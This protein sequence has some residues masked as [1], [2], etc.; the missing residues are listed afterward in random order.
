MLPVLGQVANEGAEL[1]EI[2]VAFDFRTDASGDPDAT[3]PTLLRYHHLLWSKPLPSR[4]MFELVPVARKPFSLA[5]ES[6]LGT[7]RLTSDAVLPTF[8]RRA[9][10]QSIVSQV[11]T[12]YLDFM[13][14]ITYTVGGMML[15]PGN[16]VD[17]KWTINQA[18]G[19]IRALADRFDLT[20][21]CVRLHY[22]DDSRHPLAAVFSRYT[23][24]F[25]LFDDFTGFV[26]FW[27]LDDL[28]DSRGRVRLFIPSDDFSLPALPQDLNGYREFCERT[29]E[30]VTARNERIRRLGR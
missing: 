28:V 1:S 22:A 9:E 30:F 13:N 7:F 18:R 8:T 5:H 15:W 24:F 14:S 20:L 25:G 16:R 23:S 12:E 29:V 11:S 27:M 17:G 19:C 10:M 3:S 21:E 2:D 26:E 6:D 4:G